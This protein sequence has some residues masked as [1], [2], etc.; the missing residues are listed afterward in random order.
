[1]P[2]L[3]VGHTDV[4]RELSFV[5][6]ASDQGPWS[7][8]DDGRMV[9][10]RALRGDR[11]WLGG[12]RAKPTIAELHRASRSGA[13]ATV[14]HGH[15]DDVESDGFGQVSVEHLGWGGH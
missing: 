12:D 4:L 9:S 7:Q 13:G 1:M 5:G 11:W 14:A 15:G 6:M 2:T 10:G 8:H 3:S